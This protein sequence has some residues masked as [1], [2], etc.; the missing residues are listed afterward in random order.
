MKK[1]VVT[2]LV[3]LLIAGVGLGA[4]FYYGSFSEGT[5][6]GTVVKV[7]K[8]GTFF[9]TYEGQLNMES[10][11]AVSQSKQL[12]EI[13]EFSIPKDNDSIFSLLQEVAL[14]GERVNVR[15][16]EKYIT[17]P[18]RGDTKYF[19]NGVDRLD[20]RQPAESKKKKDRL[21]D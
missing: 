4:F 13:F 10:F 21:F 18:W 3:L 6:A 20:K 2:V 12:N 19:V 17:V 1:I 14:S 5:R 15:Y 16:Q 9:K 8:R 7:S 11:G